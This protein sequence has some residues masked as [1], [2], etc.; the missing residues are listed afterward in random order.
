[1]KRAYAASKYAKPC[2]AYCRKHYPDEAEAIFRR[3]EDYYRGFMRDMPDLGENMMAKNML[4]W[5]TILAFYEA[6]GRRMDGETLLEIKRLAVERLRFLGKL[7]DGNKSRWLYRLFEKTYVR[8]HKMQKEHQAR[9]EWMDSWRVEINPDHRT[10]GFCFHLVGC[11]IAKHAREHGY[12]ATRSCCRI[13]AGR[14]ISLR[15]SCTRV[16]SGRRPRRSAARAAITGTWAIGARRSGTM[17]SCR[18][19]EREIGKSAEQGVPVPRSFAAFARKRAK[20]F[21][22]AAAIW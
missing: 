1:M 22:F 14:T 12:T 6:S 8:F 7:V 16:S 9:G 15:R 19:S 2:E 20:K 10:E 13:C 21:A 18:R 17:R 11:P 4:D 5:F 3:A